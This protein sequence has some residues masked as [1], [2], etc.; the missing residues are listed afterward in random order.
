MQS[1]A[2]S[3]ISRSAPL[4]VGSLRARLD[5]PA[6]RPAL[7]SLK[8]ENVPL[9]PLNNEELLTLAAAWRTTRAAYGD[10]G[11]DAVADALESLSAARSA[12]P[13]NRIRAVVNRLSDLMQLS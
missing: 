4:L 6:R 3:P 8:P 11:A 2:S 12:P 5:A 7:R 9:A 10:Q 13:P 1:L